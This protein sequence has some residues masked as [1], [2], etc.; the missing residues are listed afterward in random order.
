MPPRRFPPAV[1]SPRLCRRL[2]A[3]A[4]LLLAGCSPEGLAF[5]QDRRVEI[6]EP[7]DLEEVRLPVTIRWVAE[8]FTAMA[9]P[10]GSSQPDRGRFAVLV[11][12][13][14]MPPGEGLDWFA[15]DDEQCVA[16][17]CPDDEWLASQGIHV[18]SET[19][20]TLETLPDRREREGALDQHE[21]TI[22]LLDGSDQRIGEAAFAVEFTVV[23]DSGDAS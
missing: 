7:D 2:L 21:V 23:R 5:V 12:R 20:V 6:V 22:V 11:N 19:A 9:S 10:D 18:T 17:A 3:V 15:R 8:D 14:P 16:P 1:P 13:A 4:V